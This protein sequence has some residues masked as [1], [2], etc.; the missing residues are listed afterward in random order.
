ARPAR[1]GCAGALRE[2]GAALLV[3]PPAPDVAAARLISG[4]RKNAKAQRAQRA[5]KGR[6]RRWCRITDTMPLP[7]PLL[8]RE[9]PLLTDRRGELT[10]TCPP[11]L[12]F[13]ALSL[14]PLRLCVLPRTRLLPRQVELD[15]HFRELLLL[16]RGRGVAEEVG[17][18]L[19]LRE[20]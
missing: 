8:L 14:R 17:A 4:R 13:F 10:P 16:D 15:V 11:S 1:R 6:R 18:A 2:R 7:R 9:G 12:H 5:S 3:R 20:G 19:G